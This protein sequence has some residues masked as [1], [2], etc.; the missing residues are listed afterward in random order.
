M[1]VTLDINR[2]IRTVKPNPGG[3]E[4]WHFNAI[5]DD[6]QYRFAVTFYEGNPFSTRYNKKLDH[7]MEQASL[8]ENFPAVNI[9]V[10]EDNEPIFY[11]FTEYE[12][13]EAS[14]SDTRPDLAIGTN[15]MSTEIG[16]SDVTYTL[17]LKDKLPNGDAIVA[18]LEFSS[19]PC[20]HHLLDEDLDNT[21]KHSWSLI[22]PKAEV[23][24]KI[25]IYTRNEDTNIITF[26]GIGYHDHN[27]GFEPMKNDF[28]ELYRGRFHFEYGTL[29]FYV[30]QREEELQHRAWIISNSGDRLLHSFEEIT[31]QDKSLSLFGLVSARKLILHSDNAHVNIQQSKVLDNGPFYQRFSSDAFLHVPENDAVEVSNG[32]SEYVRADR[33]H[34]PMFRPLINMRIRYRGKP[35]HWIQYSK[36]LYR[37]IW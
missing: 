10:Y 18:N 36:K 11:S 1:K 32:F 27:L 33:I 8:P 24:G 35:P 9:S 2:D 25:R 13:E 26:E 34:W 14:F 28:S 29:I 20:V 31:L 16:D 5:S 4:W 6:G 21:D 12:P 17:H 30:I 15:K 3:Y 23:S 37:W 7:G 22:Q 19:N